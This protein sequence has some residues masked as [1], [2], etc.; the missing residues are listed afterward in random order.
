MSHTPLIITGLKTTTL[1]WNLDHIKKVKTQ[2]LLLLSLLYCKVIGER[3]APLRRPVPDSV[4]WAQL[5][6]CGHTKVSEFIE[7]IQRQEG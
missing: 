7:A 3:T 2:L 5:E 1:S 6:S 4:E